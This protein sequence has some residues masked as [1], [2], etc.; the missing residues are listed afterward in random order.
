[1]ERMYGFHKDIKI[2]QNINKKDK[3]EKEFLILKDQI[4]ERYN[5]TYPCGEV[6]YNPFKTN[7]IVKLNNL[8]YEPGEWVERMIIPDLHIILKIKKNCATIDLFACNKERIDTIKSCF[9]AIKKLE[10]H[11]S[12]SY[13]DES[14][15]ER[16]C[17]ISFKKRRLSIFNKESERERKKKDIL[18]SLNAITGLA[19]PDLS[20]YK[21]KTAARKLKAVWSPT[22][23]ME[24]GSTAYRLWN[25]GRNN[26][27]GASSV[28]PSTSTGDTERI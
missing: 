10:E 7:H 25:D 26:S 14:N 19:T 11:F 28:A 4:I 8:I 13:D 15:L 3:M 6:F 2:E 21:T 20:R 22:P 12:F 23:S 16:S 24:Y 17:S 27:I 5:F 18:E 9:G 1:M